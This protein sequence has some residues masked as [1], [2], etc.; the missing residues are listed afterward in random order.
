MANM[1]SEQSAGSP[2][3]GEP[4]FLAV[5]KLR[6]PHGLKGEMLMDVLTDFPERLTPGM[7]VYVGSEHLP[8]K[9]LSCRWHL[10]ALLVAFVEYPDQESVA[11]L[12]NQL[13]YVP[14]EDRPDLPEGEYY[15]HQVLGLRVVSDEGMV[16]GAVVD[17]LETGANDV[18]VVRHETGSE[19]LLPV[20]DE[21]ILQ[22]DLA[23]G[24]LR[25]HLLPGLIP[26]KGI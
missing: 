17:I 23:R 10:K 14:T 18:F 8:L 20:I 19:I 24:E 15:H 7:I 4:V 21:V 22:V 6:R 12:R 1:R 9:F 26:S 2:P 25:V 11:D 5:G 16:L 3:E 13:V